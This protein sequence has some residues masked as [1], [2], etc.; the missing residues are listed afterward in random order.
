MLVTDDMTPWQ[1]QEY[2]Q[3]PPPS[4]KIEQFTQNTKTMFQKPFGKFGK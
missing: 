4:P 2:A 1:N 3:L